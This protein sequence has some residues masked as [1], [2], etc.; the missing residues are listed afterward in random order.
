MTLGYVI[1]TL[2]LRLRVHH[3]TAYVNLLQKRLQ[4]RVPCLRATEFRQYRGTTR[5]KY[6][7]ALGSSDSC[8]KKVT[9]SLR[10]SWTDAVVN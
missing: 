9:I 2:L 7:F 6:Q 4:L 10:I 5:M 3:H 8:E 1:V